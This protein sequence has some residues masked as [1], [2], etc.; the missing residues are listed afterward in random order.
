MKK[1]IAGEGTKNAAATSWPANSGAAALGRRGI[2]NTL[3]KATA[4]RFAGGAGAFATASQKD[5]AGGIFFSLKLNRAQK[6]VYQDINP[7][8]GV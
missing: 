5:H 2:M 6:V 3:T 8:P 4:L 7:L 1:L